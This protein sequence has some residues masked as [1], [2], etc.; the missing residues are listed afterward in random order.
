MPY[1]LVLISYGK[2]ETDC[3]VASLLAK[4]IFKKTVSENA[5]FPLGGG[6]FPPLLLKEKRLGDEV[7]F[8]Y[9]N[10]CLTKKAPEVNLTSGAFVPVN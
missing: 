9:C 8:H 5:P 1:S 2:V 7:N 4:S 10:G 6:G 3:F